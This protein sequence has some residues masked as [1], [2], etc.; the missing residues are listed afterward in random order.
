MSPEPNRLPGRAGTGD[1]S[2]P[3]ERLE[4]ALREFRAAA[5]SAADNSEQFWE[6]QRL[7]IHERLRPGRHTPIHRRVL[8]WASAAAAVALIWT[9]FT[10][11]R[12]QPAPD[13]VAGHDQELMFGVHDSLG[14][15]V[16]E[17]LEPALLL[18]TELERAA[19]PSARK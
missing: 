10:N 4:A 8:P 19:T 17:A 12:A 6:K 3:D 13:L 1:D 11:D 5:H 16:P 9:I 18:V 2:I 7:S 14:R 15:D